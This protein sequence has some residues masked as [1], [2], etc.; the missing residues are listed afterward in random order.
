[1]Q[2]RNVSD[3]GGYFMSDKLEVTI[4]PTEEGWEVEE[5]KEAEA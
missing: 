3:F 1:M 5:N 4:T 2:L